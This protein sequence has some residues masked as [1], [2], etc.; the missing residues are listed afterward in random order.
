MGKNK[1]YTYER[2]FWDNESLFLDETEASTNL[3]ATEDKTMCITNAYADALKF[4][5]SEGWTKG[6]AIFYIEGKEGT[7]REYNTTEKIR[8]VVGITEE[9]ANSFGLRKNILVRAGFSESQIKFLSDEDIEMVIKERVWNCPNGDNDGINHIEYLG[10]IMTETNYEV[11]GVYVSND[12]NEVSF[13]LV[14]NDDK[15]NTFVS[16]S[17]FST[18]NKQEIL[19]E[20]IG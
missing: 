5:G 14:K 16:W 6:I 15:E 9:L 11:L 12:C 3:T 2:W 20:I 10:G 4:L 8:V 1:F 17:S 18:K 7:L 19:E 13:H